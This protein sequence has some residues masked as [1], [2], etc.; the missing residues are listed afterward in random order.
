MGTWLLNTKEIKLT[1]STCDINDTEETEY[2]A[3]CCTVP[4]EQYQKM[5][6][7]TF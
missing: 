7:D 1:V 4:L 6:T 3:A 2:C 5:L